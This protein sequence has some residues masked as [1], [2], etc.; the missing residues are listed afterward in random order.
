MY[1]CVYI[2]KKVN[3]DI[4][5]LYTYGN[6]CQVT[7]SSLPILKSQLVLF[8]LQSLSVQKT[9]PPFATS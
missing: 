6:P 3:C 5:G 8:R 7:F 4:A 2:C 9:N 1:V